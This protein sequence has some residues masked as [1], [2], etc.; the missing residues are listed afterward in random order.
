MKGSESRNKAL[1]EVDEQESQACWRLLGGFG[2][3]EGDVFEEEVSV[4]VV[5]RSVQKDNLT[6]R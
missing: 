5:L 4:F 1:C 2:V 3:D 6:R